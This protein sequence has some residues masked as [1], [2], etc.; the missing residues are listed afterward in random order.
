MDRQCDRLTIHFMMDR[1]CYHGKLI[2]PK[3]DH[4]IMCRPSYHGQ[5]HPFVSIDNVGQQLGSSSHG[6]H[7]LVAKFIHSVD[8]AC[9]K[10][11]DRGQRGHPTVTAHITFPTSTASVHVQQDQ[12]TGTNQDTPPSHA[13]WRTNLTDSRPTLGH[14]LCLVEHLW[15]SARSADISR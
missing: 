3:T 5:T 1:P 9:D 14:Q 2:L 12:H 6:D 10:G 15:Q 7:S 13:A 11:I 8:R 4:L